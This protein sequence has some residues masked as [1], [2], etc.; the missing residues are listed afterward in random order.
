MPTDN[1]TNGVAVADHRV[2][3]FDTDD[4]VVAAVGSYLTAAVLEGDGVAIIANPGPSGPI[5]AIVCGR[6]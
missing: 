4:G 1:D 6:D 3:L 5:R 2:H